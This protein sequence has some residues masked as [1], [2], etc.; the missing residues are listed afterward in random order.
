[1]FSQSN[2]SF[3][4]ILSTEYYNHTGQF[5]YDYAVRIIPLS[6]EN[7]KNL[8]E[9]IDYVISMEQVWRMLILV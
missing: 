6:L 9:L 4:K 2:S 5:L 7:E 8:I 3:R 1:M